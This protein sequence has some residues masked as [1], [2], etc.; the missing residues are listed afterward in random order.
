MKNILV[1]GAYGGMGRTICKLL[2]E[3]G[4]NVFGL[5]Y[6]TNPDAENF[7]TKNF[8]FVLCDVTNPASVEKAFETMK[9]VAGTLDAIIHTAGIY[10]LDSLLEM[11]EERFCR[12]F[13]IN[14]FGVY[15]INKAFSTLL[16]KGS[17]IIITTSEL[18]PL[19]PLP[20]TGV[21]AMSKAALEKY[22]CSLRMEVN[23]LGV[24][25]SI[26]RPGA[27]KTGLLNDST[28]ALEHFCENTK[29]YQCNAQKF[30]QI[31][32]S[33]ESRNIA[34]EAIAKLALKA[35]ESKHPR[36]VYNI[37]RNIL[38]RLLNVLPDRMQ[39]GIIKMI[40]RT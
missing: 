40:L 34:P 35:L 18:A 24:S 12:I 9:S 3:K 2:I 20:F 14:L 37:N 31:V 22:A 8:H 26:I 23:L 33:V 4:Y 1:T 30:R 13:D 36:F 38:L 16:S 5:D 27:V 29:I 21:Y 39:V 25:V 10:D 11:H 17:R 15:R 7:V 32:D 6:K 28:N 19:D